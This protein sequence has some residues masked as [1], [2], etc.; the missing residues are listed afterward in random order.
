[1]NRKDI[2][3]DSSTEITTESLEEFEHE[4]KIASSCSGLVV[5]HASSHRTLLKAFCQS[6]VTLHSGGIL[7]P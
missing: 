6:C 1:M 3:E 2:F 7:S 4:M 5:S